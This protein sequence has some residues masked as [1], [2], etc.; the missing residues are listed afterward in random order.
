MMKRKNVMNKTRS[1]CAWLVCVTFAI[2]LCSP[3]F[4][5]APRGFIGD[6][7]TGWATTSKV[8]AY[9]SSNLYGRDPVNTVDGSGISEDGLIHNTSVFPPAWGGYGG[10]WM[11]NGTPAAYPYIRGNTQWIRFDLDKVHNLSQM[12]IWNWNDASYPQQGMKRVRIIVSNTDTEAGYL[13]GDAN[14]VFDGII[15]MAPGGGVSAFVVDFGGREARYILMYIPAE[16]GTD[17]NW[18]GGTLA[19]DGLSEVR[20]YPYDA[21]R[22]FIGDTGSGW[23]TSSAVT[24]Y[25][26]SNHA[27]YLNGAHTVDGSG[28]NDEGL[29]HTSVA[30]N[31]MW[32]SAE[33]PADYHP[34]VN[35][36]SYYVT[37]AFD[38]AYSIDEMW[39]WNY[40]EAGASYHATG[41]GM[42]QI[43]V[44]ASLTD[45]EA[46]WTYANAHPVFEG[47]LP[48]APG[49]DDHLVDLKIDFGGI[50]AAYVLITSA[51]G[52]NKNWCNPGDAYES[53]NG[54]SEIRFYRNPADCTEAK[55]WGL[56]AASDL[57]GDCRVNFTDFAE[58]AQ[59]WM[60]CMNPQDANCL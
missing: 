45:N 53:R 35:A 49:T 4:A 14:P 39:I 12:W 32:L 52:S 48:E 22:H 40:N 33:A 46:G 60:Q 55:E 51:V 25:P 16:A 1:C 19:E 23:D 28:I 26:A 17:H 38:H 41:A 24:A 50:E 10:M 11:D 56:K 27:V 3:V 15:P 9:C 29:A 47:L 37:Y 21:P 18:S 42:K 8:T 31:F 36:H 59:S 30:G 5:D 6:T 43:R 7:G 57:N 54:L 58:F 2:V 34:Y 13:A 20:F 44:L